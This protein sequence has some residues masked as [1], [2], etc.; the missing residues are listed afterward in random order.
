[1][2]ELPAALESV[3]GIRGLK[4]K[5]DH[6]DRENENR[7][8]SRRWRMGVQ[9]RSARK[10]G[11]ARLIAIAGLL[12][13]VSLVAAAGEV[14][15]AGTTGAEAAPALACEGT[16]PVAGSKTLEAMRHAVEQ[17]A[18]RDPAMRAKPPAEPSRFEV[19]NGRGF[20]YS[21]AKQSV[22]PI[23]PGAQAAP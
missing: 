19:L 8:V 1:M 4:I 12:V 22:A 13:T 16:A 7:K 17:A 5:A 23:P 11:P 9:L 2:I 21:R 3:A 20:N 6:A 18:R 15:I 14:Q 10:I